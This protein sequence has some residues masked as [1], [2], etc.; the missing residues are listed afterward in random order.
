[1][2]KVIV[3]TDGAARGNPGPAAYGVVICD[4]EGKVLAEDGAYLGKLTNNQAEY[5]ALIVGL[6]KALAVGATYVAV[7][8]DSELMVKQLNGVYKVKNEGIKP[9]FTKVTTLLTR[10]ER[11]TIQHVRREQNAHADA[12]ANQAI[13]MHFGKPV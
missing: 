7:R 6:E 1:M 4:A 8:A 10:L 5:Q 12:L 2:T 9:L 11:Y 3:Y 13:D